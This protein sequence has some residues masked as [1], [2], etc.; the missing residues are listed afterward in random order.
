MNH[1][2]VLILILKDFHIVAGDFAQYTE[3]LANMYPPVH[4]PSMSFCVLIAFLMAVTKFSLLF[5][6]DRVSLGSFA[7][8]GIF[9]V[10]EAGLDLRDPPTSVF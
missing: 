4:K 10:N 9:F 5:F 8:P 6:Q 7:C 2:V 1:K 3:C